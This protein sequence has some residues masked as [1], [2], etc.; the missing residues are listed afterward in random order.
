VLSRSPVPIALWLSALAGPATV[1]LGPAT[2]SALAAPGC[3]GGRAGAPATQTPA[4]LFSVIEV[5]R[6]K[7]GDFLGSYILP[8]TAH[9]KVLQEFGGGDGRVGIHGGGGASLLDPLATARS[10]GC[11]RLA[12]RAIEWIARTVGHGGLPGTPVGVR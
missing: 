8:T 4:G 1:L 6:W 5:W 11:I 10:R 3:R 2:R 7:P 12:N 9:S